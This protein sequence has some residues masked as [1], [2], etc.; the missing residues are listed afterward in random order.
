MT[1]FFMY[2]TELQDIEQMMM[3]VPNFIPRR[4][5]VVVKKLHYENEVLTCHNCDRYNVVDVMIML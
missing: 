2:G 5:G 3:L 1:K 4:S